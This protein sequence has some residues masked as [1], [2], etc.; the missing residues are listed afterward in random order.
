MHN[1][2]LHY[3]FVNTFFIRPLLTVLFVLF[4]F[5]GE[6]QV[7]RIS[8]K[9]T[10]AL[11]GEPVPFASVVF[12]NSTIGASAN[13]DG[14]YSL[15]TDTPGDSLTAQFLGYL[16]VS[17]PVRK[18]QTQTINFLLKASKVELKEAVIYAG[19]NPANIIIKKVVANRDHNNYDKLSSYSFETYNKV[20]FDLTNIT[21]KFK[22][23]KIFKPFAF[24]FDNIDSTTTN[25]KPFLPVFITESLSDVYH[26]TNPKDKREIIKASKISGVENETVTQFLGDMYQNI[27]I[28]DNFMDIF[29][30]K[31]VSP[32]S[33]IGMLYYKYYLLDSLYI[34]DK[35][36]YKLKFKPRRP[37][38]LT[39]TGEIF[40]HDSTWAVKKVNMRISNKANINFVEDCA[41][42]KEYDYI[43]NTMW[44]LSKD[45][46]VI[47]FTARDKGL[48]LIGRK[49]TS[50][51]NFSLNQPIPQQFLKGAQDIVVEEGALDKDAEF[52]NKARHDS[53]NDREKKIYAM[54][55]TI[56][57]LPAYKTYVDIITLFVTG[58]KTIGDFDFG[59]YFTLFSFNDIEGY[60]FRLGGK[61]N[62]NFSKHLKLEGFVA[63]GTKD[64]Q[65]KYSIG[66]RYLFTNKPR[67]GFGF[68][69]RHDV[70]QLGQSDNAF[71][72]DNILASLFRRSAS[73]KLTNAESE[74]V[75]FEKEWLSGVST[76][77]SFEHNAFSPLGKL[78]Y[79]YYTT[80]A[81]DVIR[82]RINTSDI[83]AY[84]RFAYREKFIE[85]K[86]G[87]VSLGSQYPVL[88]AIYT[89]GL[90]GVLKSDF[91]YQKF[92]LK[93]D[94]YIYTAPFGYFYYV[95]EAGK[96][97]GKLPYPLLEVHRGNE[98]YFYDYLAFNLMNYYEFVSD[99]YFSFY[100]T[101]HFEG[102][103]LDKIPL[104]KKLKWREV[105]GIRGV[106][107]SMSQKNL[108]LMV[109][110]EFNTLS[111]KP[112]LE[113]Q[114]GI[115]NILKIIRVDFIYRLSY[116][117]DKD[118]PR[119]GIRG[120]L[121]LTF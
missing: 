81:K 40:I 80:D 65:F 103:F 34:G 97:W 57:T 42:V 75:Y 87:R 92:V 71:Q 19:E 83:S 38:D 62:Y 1:E 66:A 53:L 6:A 79:S 26:S 15:E 115:E 114:F 112:Y 94:D 96:V 24:I 23:K 86:H 14:I 90:K 102:F 64:E 67:M 36:C 29:G 7:T 73:N 27:N 105:A 77:I 117:Q 101:H 95:I 116:L 17:L 47:E 78:D 5:F 37:E 120:S 84:F 25:E 72:D 45:L 9:V 111:K 88:Q 74:R 16:P 10:D 119:F 22:N 63:Y 100:F 54:V 104:M 107:G 93:V 12:K 4:C 18:G 28:Y 11:T 56:K 51:K 52:W 3:L 43:D 85:S 68:K 61:T 39:F 70:M 33:S 20:E 109:N 49:S 106:Y 91:D 113:A 44:M 121:Q 99:Q 48:G 82:D 118:A 108:D 21:E 59:P 76:R 69:Y 46:L 41:V 35:Y 2:L 8:G 30:K 31:F 58:Y 110:P 32:I 55:D 98:S 89:Q 13:F 50:Y 60:R